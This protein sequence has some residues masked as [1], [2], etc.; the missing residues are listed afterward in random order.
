[1]P[2]QGERTAELIAGLSVGTP[3]VG[4]LHPH[5]A[6][7]PIHVNGAG[8][9]V[10]ERSACSHGI[11]ITTDSDAGTERVTFCRVRSLKQRLFGPHTPIAH[12]HDSRAGGSIGRLIVVAAFWIDSRGKAIFVV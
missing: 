9:R 2:V 11:A 3:D 6:I 5:A 10:L 1:V 12:E 8:I 7:P 4:E